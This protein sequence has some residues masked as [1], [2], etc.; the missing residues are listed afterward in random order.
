LG[1][2]ISNRVRNK[3]IKGEGFISADSSKV[4]VLVVPANEELVVVHETAAVVECANAA[5]HAMAG[6]AT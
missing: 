4:K 2:A 6:Q 1:E 3:F 5:P